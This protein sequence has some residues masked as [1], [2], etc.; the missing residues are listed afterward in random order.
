MRDTT[1]RDDT[2]A[3]HR[4][5]YDNPNPIQRWVLARFFQKMASWIRLLAPKSTL[6]FGCGEGLLLQAL[7]TRGAVLPHYTGLDL[8]EDALD[9]ARR[10]NLPS[11][12]FVN[13]DL[14]SWESPERFDLV[15]AS[16]VLEHLP[17]P[18]P[19]MKKLGERCSGHLILSVPHEPFFQVS[20]LVRGRDIKRL[21]NHPEHVNRWTLQGF[22]S[23]V[24]TEFDV[25]LCESS[26]PFTICVATPRRGSS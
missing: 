25:V 2:G 24:E 19:V 21:G 23:F 7:R 18:F 15:L 9:F 1:I 13:A 3:R 5:K 4:A 26:F 14:R 17:E 6:E 11:D 12:R 10:I 20:N 8:R 16:Q 22:R